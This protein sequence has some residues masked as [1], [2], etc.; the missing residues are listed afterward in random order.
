[1]MNVPVGMDEA[2]VALAPDGAARNALA[3]S[4]SE[5]RRGGDPVAGAT[6]MPLRLNVGSDCPVD[7]N[8]VSVAFATPLAV[9]T[10]AYAIAQVAPAASVAPWQSS[11]AFW[12][13]RAPGP[14]SASLVQAEPSARPSQARSASRRPASVACAPNGVWQS[15]SGDLVAWFADLDDNILSLTEFVAIQ[16]T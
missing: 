4:V 13:A 6:P 16:S 2:L 12:N 15:P 7:E 3:D 5:L 8:T 9:G 10:N 14:V 11:E 1:M